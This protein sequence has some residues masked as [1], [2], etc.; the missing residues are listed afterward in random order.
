MLE[1]GGS[2][3]EDRGDHVVVRTPA[4]PTFHWGNCLLVTDADCVEDAERWTRAFDVEFPSAT[5][6]A[7][8][9][10]RM[11]TDD[12]SWTELGLELGLDETLVARTM[13]R[14]TQLPPGYLV[15]PIAGEDWEQVVALALAENVRSGPWEA[16]SYEQ[17][18]RARR[19]AD[20]GLCERG[21]A[22]FFGAFSGDTL[23]AS[24]GVVRCGSTARYQNVMTD[25]PHRRRG[26]A[27]HLLGVA[28]ESA[29]AR[30]CDRWVIVTESTNPAGRVYR[31]VGFEPELST[32][33]AY[34]R[35]R[36]S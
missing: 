19:Q 13:P 14:R 22:A 26:L 29:G 32:A 2:T 30:D 28:A 15:R 16:T 17:F 21:L 20:R 9:L 6:T 25:A 33:Q 12:V 27:S 7:I 5:W 8:G 4:N 35:S 34:R 3:V 36:R 18:E 1:Y 10:P 31:S 11:P 23:A 24:L